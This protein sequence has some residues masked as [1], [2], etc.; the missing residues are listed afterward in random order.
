MIR[1]S[2]LGN[3]IFI[4]FHPINNSQPHHARLKGKIIKM[5]IQESHKDVA[6]QAGGDMRELHMKLV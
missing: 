3:P 4:R 6:T 1:S 2:H 5:L